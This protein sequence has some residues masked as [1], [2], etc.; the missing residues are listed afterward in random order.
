M[1]LLE[2]QLIPKARQSLEIA[3]A[4]YLAGTIDFFNLMDTERTLLNFE[5]SAV[6]ARTQREIVLSRLSLLIAGEPP[7]ETGVVLRWRNEPFRFNQNFQMRNAMNTKRL[8]Q[9]FATN[10]S[11]GGPPASSGFY[12]TRTSRP[13]SIRGKIK[14]ASL[15]V[16][17]AAVVG[18]G[19]FAADSSPKPDATN[20]RRCFIRQDALHLRHASV[21]HPGSS[22]QLPDLRHETGA[23]PQTGGSD[24]SHQRSGQ[25]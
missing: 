13:R 14:F 19:L 6:E 22:G 3:R 25:R 23:G 16:L 5:L 20:Y 10:R 17:L 9:N 1:T 2:N 7:A 18:A 15:I 11:A 24:R 4:G 8:L 21:D 12:K